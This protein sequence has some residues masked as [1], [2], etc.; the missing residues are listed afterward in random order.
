MKILQLQILQTSNDT[1]TIN[2]DMERY[3]HDLFEITIPALA[4]RD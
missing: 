2:D 1:M 3:G 4:S